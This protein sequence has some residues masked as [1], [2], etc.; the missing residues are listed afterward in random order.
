MGLH[1]SVKCQS[2]GLPALKPCWRLS[3]RGQGGPV[4]TKLWIA[5]RHE[6]P[7]LSND[8]GFH[9]AADCAPRAAGH[10][11]SQGRPFSAGI[12]T[13]GEPGQSPRCAGMIIGFYRTGSET[14][15]G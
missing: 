9:R 10:F 11:P 12:G 15:E 6:L 13:P 14:L 5:S 8:M 7:I 3:P 1:T 2:Y 4:L